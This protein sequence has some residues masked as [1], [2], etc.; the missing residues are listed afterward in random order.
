MTNSL[1]YG[2]NLDLLRESISSESVALIEKTEAAVEPKKR[3]LYKP[4][5]PKDVNPKWRPCGLN[6][7][8]VLDRNRI[9]L[10]NGRL[11]E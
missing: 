1:Y 2:D 6:E 3:G 5:E 8:C 4:R 7:D 10:A 9:N 11:I